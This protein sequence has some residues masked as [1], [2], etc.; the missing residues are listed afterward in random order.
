[1]YD[2]LV[3]GAA[4]AARGARFLLAHPRL[5]KWVIAPFVAA[6]VLLGVAIWA[7]FGWLA[8][9]SGSIESRLPDWLGAVAGVIEI[10]LLLLL[11]LIGYFVYVSV[12]SLISAPFNEF[13]SE[14]MEEILTGET[15][16]S[17][18][19][20]AFVRDLI[21][22]IIH[23]LRRL[24]LYLF[25]VALLFLLGLLVPVVGS[26]LA[27]VIGMWMTA[28]FAAYD[29]YDAVWAR[30]NWPY[31]AKTGYLA[32]HR[33]RTTGLGAA[34]SLLL[35]VPIVNFLALSVGAAGATLAY[36]DQSRPQ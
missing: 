21:V 16:P 9:L 25:I 1:M 28:R 20:F 6:A 13:L 33:A 18:S 5:W 27:A 22:G 8:S 19:L 34:I 10:F 7:M 32:E 23:G 35:L 3:R 2:G 29:A 11:L 12:V 17:F 4:D 26:I 15:G 30:K 31:R 14:D 24:I 36:L